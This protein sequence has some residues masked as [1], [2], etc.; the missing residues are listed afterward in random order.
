MGSIFL[1]V[2]KEAIKVIKIIGNQLAAQVSVIP[3]K[4]IPDPLD[5]ILKQVSKFLPK[6]NFFKNI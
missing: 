3:L 4:S 2:D 5:A 1:I 6:L